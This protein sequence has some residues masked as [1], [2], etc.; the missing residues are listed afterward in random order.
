VSVASGSG[1]LPTK[2][3]LIGTRR[4]LARSKSACAAPSAIGADVAMVARRAVDGMIEATKEIGGNAEEVAKVAVTGAI[5]AS[6]SIGNTAVKAVKDMLIG[7]V[8]GVK[9]VNRPDLPTGKRV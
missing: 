8:E 4:R 1:V 9:D 3:E 7:V 6:S 5:D 2:I